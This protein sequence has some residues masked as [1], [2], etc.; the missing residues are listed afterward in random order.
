MNRKIIVNTLGKIALILGGLLLLPLAVSVIY[1]EW[2]QALSFLLTAAISAA[3]GFAAVRLTKKEKAADRMIF[4]REGLMIVGLAWLGVSLI[5]ALPFVISG[6]IPS[7]IDA[8]FETASGFSTTGASI[9]RNIEGLS[10]GMLFWRSFTHWIGGMGVLVFLMALAP[11]S[12]DT[13]RQVHIMKA[14]MPGPIVG[15]LVPRVKD[16]A[17]VLYY[18]YIGLTVAE[19]VML[20]CGGMSLYESVIH[21]M[22][23]AGTGGFSVNTGSI[24][25]YSPYIQWVVFA[26]MLLFSV[27]FNLYYLILIKRFRDAF[28]SRE[29]WL[30]F[31]IVAAAAVLIG[32]NTYNGDLAETVRISA[33][34]TASFVSTTGYA[35]TTAVNAWPTFSKCILVALMFIGGC[36]G[37]TGGGLKLSRVMIMFKSVGRSLR[38]NASPRSVRSV[39]L[40]GKTVDEETVSGAGNYFMLYFIILAVTTL[41]ISF[42]P[43]DF[44]MLFTSALSCLNNIGPCFSAK[45]ANPTFADYTWFSKIVLSLAMLLGRLELYPLLFAFTPGA[46]TRKSR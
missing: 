18:I 7:Y 6:D 9:L 28:S 5:G 24:G 26:F 39:R 23:T 20:L 32:I 22:G 38:R 17:R 27:N 31:G 46:W 36:A 11:S 35:T 42:E 14:E 10:R 21:S 30:F 8:F 25:V 2:K 43:F 4:T 12:P 33:F 15:K 13:G 37:S 3:G 19:T 45:I 1:G 16:T 41:L 44:E 29:L 40:D 34:Q